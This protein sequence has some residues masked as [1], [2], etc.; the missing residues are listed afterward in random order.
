[1]RI[2]ENRLAQ[3]VSEEDAIFAP[4][5]TSN[6]LRLSVQLH[7]VLKREAERGGRVDHGA[8][9]AL[10]RLD[11]FNVAHLTALAQAPYDTPDARRLGERALE[12]RVCLAAGGL[13]QREATAPVEELQALTP[14]TLD[15]CL[16]H[17]LA[18]RGRLATRLSELVASTPEPDLG[19]LRDFCEELSEE[20]YPEAARALGR[21]IRLLGLPR[22]NA[23]VSHGARSLGMRAFGA[24]EP[25]VLVG[26][27]HLS[28]SGSATLHGRELD[29]AFGAELSHLAFGHQR[30]TASEVW[31]GA[32]GKTRDALMAI[33]FVLPF[34]SELGGQRTRNWLARVA[35]E[36]LGRAAEGALV[37]DQLFG[38]GKSREPGLGQRNEELIAAHR[39]VQLSADRAG[40]VACRS[41]RA[42][43]RAT[44]LGR[45]EYHSI[46]H[47]SRQVPLFEAL[48]EAEG[49]A[50][51]A[52][53]RVRLRALVAF[54]LS[55]EFDRVAGSA[56]V[57][58]S[59][60]S[61]Y[62]TESPR[63]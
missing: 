48:D 33:G 62:F 57:Q 43:L 23:Y 1:R 56:P 5:G 29:F 9:A 3:S 38:T 20:R 31:M 24:R 54:H 36:A 26:Q 15:R 12:A 22:V 8:L 25:F 51:L 49:S 45:A 4:E 7:E 28:E 55:P 10:A 2:V 52:D 39:L 40:L 14:E 63:R 27:S 6:A 41:L 34:L 60:S 11:P 32:A 58:Y 18:R 50:A 53:L 46:L 42:A 30:V 37:L 13:H 21:A 35:P 47:A 17:P 61:T 44:L 19:F 59:S 16:R